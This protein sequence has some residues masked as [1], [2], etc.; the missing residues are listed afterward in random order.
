[1][2]SVQR[3]TLITCGAVVVVSVLGWT[4]LARRRRSR[5]RLRHPSGAVQV[6]ICLKGV[7]DAVSAA[8]GGAHRVE[9]CDN[10]RE[11]GTTPSIGMVR[12]CVRQL[13]GGRTEV[14]VIVRPRGG[15]F[16]YTEAEFRSMENDVV[17]IRRAGADGVVFGILRPDGTIDTH[18]VAVL[19]AAARPMAVTFHRAF[20][21]CR[22]PFAA[23][24]S[25]AEMGF[26]RVLT[27]GQAPTAWEGR[28][29][30]KRLVVHAAAIIGATNS[31]VVVAAGSG[32]SAL[33]VAALVDY[34]GCLHVHAGSSVMSSVASGME[35]RPGAG[36]D[37]GEDVGGQRQPVQMGGRGGSCS[38]FV[39][40]RTSQNKVQELVAAVAAVRA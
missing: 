9:L 4:K 30:L 36:G 23:M 16:H 31:G 21:M 22:D 18:R 37:V 12:E 26:D 40:E 1:M 3:A 2:S 6:E 10:L 35:Y 14:H 20:D 17:E 13:A 8:A 15:D 33:N 39:I 34:T 11:G 38:E 29:L 28:E 32:V 25:L 19:I 7:D 24:N 27:S 5:Q